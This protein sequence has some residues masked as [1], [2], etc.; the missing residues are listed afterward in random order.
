MCSHDTA[1]THQREQKMLPNKPTSD[2]LLAAMNDLG[3]AQDDASVPSAVP[4][5]RLKG[6]MPSRKR[7]FEPDPDQEENERKAVK[8]PI[9]DGDVMRC[10]AR[11]RLLLKRILGKIVKDQIVRRV[12][13]IQ[14][15]LPCE[16]CQ[17]NW[18]GQDDHACLFFGDT[19]EY[20]VEDYVSEH[21]KHVASSIDANEIFDVFY[22]VC[23]LLV[24]MGFTHPKLSKETLNDTIQEILLGWENETED[25]A[26]TFNSWSF[27]NV[28]RLLDFVMT[29]HCA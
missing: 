7:T 8:F 3:T 21:Y 29:S 5:K 23:Q 25:I 16:G 11:V 20:R 4:M 18:P 9:G 14:Q 15:Q 10:R 28:T 22:A 19:P 26:Q 17:E 24:A 27:L 6:K 13:H 2:V 12:Y 1:S